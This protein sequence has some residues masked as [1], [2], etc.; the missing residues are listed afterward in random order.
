MKF[1]KKFLIIFLCLFPMISFACSKETNICLFNPTESTYQINVT[2]IVNSDWDGD[3]RPDHNFVNV[4]ISP[5]QT[6]CKREEVSCAGEAHFSFLINDIK[7]PDNV[8]KH[9][10]S[11]D[12]DGWLIDKNGILSANNTHKYDWQNRNLGFSCDYGEK[13][14]LFII[15]SYVATVPSN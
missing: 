5:N 4:L 13:C 9:Y 1:S 15:T 3:S 2:D 10:L 12:V 11:E 14:A 6:I 8:Y 7:S